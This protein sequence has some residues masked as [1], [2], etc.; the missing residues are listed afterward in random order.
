MVAGRTKDVEFARAVL[1]AGIVCP[2]ELRLRLARLPEQPGHLAK[3]ILARID[4]WE[5]H[6]P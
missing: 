1:R 2:G 3:R 6:V 5:S 4:A